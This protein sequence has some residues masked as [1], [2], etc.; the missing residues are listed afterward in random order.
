MAPRS[1]IPKD[2]SLVCL[3]VDVRPKSTDGESV[4]A[5]TNDG[6]LVDVI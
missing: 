5:Y 2:Y 6:Q 1:E 3:R 4:L